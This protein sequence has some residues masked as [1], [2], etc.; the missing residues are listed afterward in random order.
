MNPFSD[1]LRHFTVEKIMLVFADVAF[2]VFVVECLICLD[3]GV[4]PQ[5]VLSKTAATGEVKV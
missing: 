2:H 1:G 3:K 4:P 5:L